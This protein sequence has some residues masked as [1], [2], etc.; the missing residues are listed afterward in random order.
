MW[1]SVNKI[2]QDRPA[3]SKMSIVGNGALFYFKMS[4]CGDGVLKRAAS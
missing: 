2:Y 1:T 4:S 3:N